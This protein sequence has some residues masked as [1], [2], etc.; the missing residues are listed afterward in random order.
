MVSKIIIF[1]FDVQ[2]TSSDDALKKGKTFFTFFSSFFVVHLSRQRGEPQF[3]T[4][5]ESMFT[6]MELWI[7]RLTLGFGVPEARTTRRDS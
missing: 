1:H 4:P 3:E 2:T 7:P 5:P 6:S